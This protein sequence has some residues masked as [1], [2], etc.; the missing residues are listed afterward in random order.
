MYLA[1]QRDSFF[2]RSKNCQRLDTNV[3][4]RHI[5]I[6]EDIIDSGRT[7]AYL[8]DLFRYR[9]AASVKIVTLFR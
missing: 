6:V 3:E 2:R 4:G 5:L 8:V 7:L 1:R 9:K